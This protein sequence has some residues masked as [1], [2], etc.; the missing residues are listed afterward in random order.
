M[1]PI[2]RSSFGVVRA[3]PSIGRQQIAAAA[4]HEARGLLQWQLWAGHPK[5]GK[6]DLNHQASP[7]RWNSMCIYVCIY[8]Y[9][10]IYILTYINIYI[11]LE[12][13]IIYINIYIYITGGITHFLRGM[14]HQFQGSPIFLKRKPIWSNEHI[15]WKHDDSITMEDFF[16]WGRTIRIFMQ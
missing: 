10:Y 6:W 16:C 5:L 3:P 9:L 13:Y 7:N 8:I 15:E 1:V 4:P 12:K 11:Y 14:H 2:V